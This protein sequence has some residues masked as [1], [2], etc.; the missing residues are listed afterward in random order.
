MQ[1]Q[2][3]GYLLNCPPAS[4]PD[5]SWASSSFST[6]W[7]VSRDLECLWSTWHTHTHP[8]GNKLAQ[9]LQRKKLAWIKAPKGVHR[10]IKSKLGMPPHF[11]QPKG[12]CFCGICRSIITKKPFHMLVGVLGVAY[13][14]RVRVHIWWS[15][16]FFLEK[17]NNIPL[18]AKLWFRRA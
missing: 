7:H 3:K 6:L 14:I 2:V 17:R 15:V 18:R 10:S 4:L 12:A 13:V 16:H 5:L 11:F 1:T 8:G 9:T